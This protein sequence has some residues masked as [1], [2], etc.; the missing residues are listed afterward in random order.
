MADCLFDPV[1]RIFWEGW[2][3]GGWH[4]GPRRIYDCLLDYTSAGRY[5]RT[6]EDERYEQ[7]PGD[8]VI[9]PPGLRSE[10]WAEDTQGAK[11]HCVHF[12]WTRDFSERKP[13]LQTNAEEAFR[14]LESHPVPR[15]IAPRLPLRTR[16]AADD[17]ERD[18]LER[19]LQALRDG[20]THAHVLLW[21]LL[22]LLLERGARQNPAPLR[23]VRAGD[24]AALA[25]KHFIDS[26]YF[27]AIGYAQFCAEARMS[28]SHLCQEFTRVVG[29]APN[30]YL[31]EIRLHQARLMLREGRHSVKEVA[32]TV[33]IRDAN[34]FARAFRKRFKQSPREGRA[35]PS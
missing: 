14:T 8:L 25:V 12:S 5:V 1:V 28:K 32:H 7:E 6:L 17:P 19:L 29:L 10:G 21:P 27:D 26:H 23:A 30:A 20:R 18:L 4:E 2:C 9:I 22:R 3:R 11:R 33:G 34:Y 35:S 13:P 24:R 15:A 31:R 16:L